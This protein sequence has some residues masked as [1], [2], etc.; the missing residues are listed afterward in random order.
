[1]RE[2]P[3]RRDESFRRRSPQ[4][5]RDGVAWWEIVRQDGAYALRGLRRTPLVTMTIAV[6]FAI[7]LGTIAA[8][9]PL[10]DRL[11]FRPPSGVTDPAELRRVHAREHRPSGDV[12]VRSAFSY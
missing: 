4:P 8:V 6:T 11:F 5:G 10:L 2:G 1:H 9:F 3:M 12:F 7:G